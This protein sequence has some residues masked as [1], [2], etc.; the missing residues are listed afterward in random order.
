MRECCWFERAAGRRPVSLWDDDGI[1][2]VNYPP[3]IHGS[4]AMYWHISAPT[5]GG[6]VVHPAAIWWIN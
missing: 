1:E 2:F 5:A 3:V 4:S 6:V